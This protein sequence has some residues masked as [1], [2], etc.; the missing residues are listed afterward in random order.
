M[1]KFYMKMLLPLLLLAVSAQLLAQT[2]ISGTVKDGATQEGIAGVNIIVK[3]KVVGTITDSE[4]KYTLKVTQAPPFTLTFSFIGFHTEEKEVTDANA[5]LDLTMNE[6]ALLGQEVV[7]SASRVE[8]SILRSPV[9]I[10]KLDII[11]IKQAA[12]P[13]FYD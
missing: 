2:V 8:E 1:N 9:T 7:V 10:E 3:G 4:G 11:G 13:D 6:E 12:T 5:T